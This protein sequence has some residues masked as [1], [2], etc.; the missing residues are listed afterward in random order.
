M[1]TKKRKPTKMWWPKEL[2]DPRTLTKL[3]LVSVVREIQRELWVEWVVR[4]GKSRPQFNRDKEFNGAD[5]VDRVVESLD[6]FG[7][8]PEE[9][10]E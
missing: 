8:T 4:N 9:G 6:M 2:R 10:L 5:T 1:A 3:E 7:L